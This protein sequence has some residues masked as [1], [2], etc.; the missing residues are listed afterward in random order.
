M[1]KIRLDNMGHSYSDTLSVDDYALK[2]LTME[3]R[4]GGAYALLGPSG[5][6]KTTMLNIISGLVMPSQ[7]KVWF[8]ERNITGVPAARRNIAHVF[9]FPVIY[10]S[11]T[12][13]E[14]L[15]FPLVCRKWSTAR[16]RSRVGE[17]AELLDLGGKLHAG[18]RGLA[19]DEKQLISLGRGLVRHDVS[20]VLLDEPLTVIDPQ[21]RLHLRRK[22]KEIHGRFN[23][24][25]LYVTHDQNEAM[26]FADEVVMMNHGQVVQMGAPADLFEA[27][28]TRFVGYFIGTPAMNFLAAEARDGVVRFE[29]IVMAGVPAGDVPSGPI[30]IGIRPEYVEFT[31]SPGRNV[32]SATVVDILDFGS[33]RV[34][35]LVAAGRRV[36][37]K[38]QRERAIPAGEVWIR[39]PADKIRLYVDD[40]LVTAGGV[41]SKP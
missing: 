32:L 28:L 17:I 41:C 40:H 19:P 3:W 22:L 21:L 30:T 24:T 38:L 29:G 12:V 9:Q 39:L 11:M 20:A 34:V 18:M 14:N 1:A 6:G 31:D 37:A 4:D 10:P 15:A 2:P 13:F 23:L 7:G 33:V 26:T 8:D 35:D 16:I 25:M 5:C 27:P 36:K